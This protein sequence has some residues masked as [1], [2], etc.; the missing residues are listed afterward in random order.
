MHT[1]LAGDMNAYTAVIYVGSTFDQPVPATFM[2]D[3]L[4]G[5]H[6]VLWIDDNIWQLADF[7]ATF[8]TD[9][10]FAPFTY[11]VSTISSVSYKG[12]ALDRYTAQFAGIM[13]YSTLDSTK[14]TVLA[15]ALHAD[16]TSFP[17]AIRSKNL[18]YIGENPFVY[19]S[20]ND[21]YLIFCDLLFDLLAPTTAQQ[22]RALV[23]LEDVAADADPTALRSFA[24]YLAS[25]KVPFSI[26]TIPLYLDPNG[27]Y[28]A[29]VPETLPMRSSAVRTAIKY[30]LT[31]GGTLVMHGYT[32]QYSNIDDP[33]TGVT[34]DDFEFFRGHID[35]QNFVIYDGP[36]AEDSPTWASGRI[37]SGLAELAAS[38]LPKPGI[39][40]LPHYAGTDVDQRAI[41]LSFPTVYQRETYYGGILVGGTPNYTHDVSLFFPYVVTD[42]YGLKVIPE[43]LGNY[44]PEAINNNP[45]RLPADLLN[46][47]QIN[48]AVIRDGFASFFFHP[49]Y[50]INQLKT[51]VSGLK[52]MGYTFIAV[53]SL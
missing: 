27:F 37:A 35:A 24:D 18:T 47:A 9:Y 14:A 5:T 43:N 6:P 20:A 19:I 30:M 12:V 50:D 53:G 13:T 34:A 49:Y 51:I 41:K 8:A 3:L 45:P 26:A 28:N 31:K 46:T 36:V 16:G 52:A 42:P 7:S 4:L 39:F 40:E 21:R 1:Y 22:H 25:E 38:G 2:Q 23:R 10:G 17:W 44:E 32:H 33:Y 11:D 29:G 15:T 48:K